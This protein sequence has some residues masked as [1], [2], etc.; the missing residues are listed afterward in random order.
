MDYNKSQKGQKGFI[1]KYKSLGELKQIRV[2]VSLESDIKT[3]LELL[4]TIARRENSMVRVNKIVSKIITGL[5]D[6][7][8]E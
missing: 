5:N 8:N 3:I 6:I 2:P 1:K 7:A 4:E